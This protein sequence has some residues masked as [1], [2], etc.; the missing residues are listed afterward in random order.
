MRDGKGLARLRDDQGGAVLVEFIVAFVPMIVTFF[1]FTQVAQLF[2][3]GLVMRHAAVVA[4][5]DA[6]VSHGACI[7]NKEDL[8]DEGDAARAAVSVWNQRL[9]VVDVSTDYD[10]K[11]PFGDVKTTTSFAYDCTVP[12]G[13]LFV[14]P[15]GTVVRSFT[16]KLPHS[17]A[18][19][20]HACTT[21]SG[22]A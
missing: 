18:R 20:D 1:S 5:R 16:V 22:G 8:D 14:C 11:D 2:A 17:G 15:G 21:R 7:P 10:E 12:L 13:R 6:S 9:H 19:Y 3:A 4:A